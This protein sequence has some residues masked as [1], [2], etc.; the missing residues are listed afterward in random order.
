MGEP[1]T[2]DIR[3]LVQLVLD[4]GAV[5]CDEH[6]ID[7]LL[8]I[9]EHSAA[10]R[11]TYDALC[12]KH[13]ATVTNQMTAKW[14]KSILGWDTVAEVEARKNTLTQFYSILTPLSRKLTLEEQRSRAGNDVLAFYRRYKDSLDR[15][16]V[17]P[18]RDEL[19]SQVLAGMP[20]EE[21]YLS[22]MQER[23]IELS[24]LRSAL[25]SQPGTL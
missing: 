25:G 18:L 5:V 11:R 10:H 4:E 3:D 15:N 12:E 1:V 8:A 7:N 13:G 16:L 14:T 2:R 19:E 22:V 9:I 20:V 23:G 17:L 6:V 24:A 21:A